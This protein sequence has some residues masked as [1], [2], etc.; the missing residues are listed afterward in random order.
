MVNDLRIHMPTKHPSTKRYYYVNATDLLET[1]V[2]ISSATVIVSPV[3]AM[4]V[5]SPATLLSSG[6][7]ARTQVDAGAEDTEYILTWTLTLSDGNKEVVT[8]V[9]PVSSTRDF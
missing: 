3:G 7:R 8:M 6:T 5:T 9:I 1:G 4:T 2:T